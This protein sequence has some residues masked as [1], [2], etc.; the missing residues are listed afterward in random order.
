[1][2]PKNC[3]QPLLVARVTS[4]I[5]PLIP[6]LLL[7]RKVHPMFEWDLN[8]PPATYTTLQNARQVERRRLY[9]EVV[10]KG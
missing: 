1:M 5:D 2:Y 7:E 6:W 3:V 10:A 8:Q 4:V 9:A